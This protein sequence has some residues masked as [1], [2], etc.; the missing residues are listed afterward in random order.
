MKTF[1]ALIDALI[2]ASPERRP[3]IEQLIHDT[4]VR[5]KAV[6]ALD[7][8]GFTLA[9]R[10]DG[11]LYYLCMIRRMQ[12]LTLTIV[13]SHRGELVKHEA[14]NLLAV[15]EAPER[16]AEAAVAMIQAATTE[17]VSGRP[18]L[19]FSIGID[20]GDILVIDRVDCF[21]D[22]VNL[23]HKLGEDIA[24][25]GEVLITHRVREQIRDASRFR[26]REIPLSLSGLELATYQIS[27]VNA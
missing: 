20:Y 2:A 16:A 6:L 12:K 1:S 10:R 27:D 3:A 24:E 9:V 22:A 13:V 23:A 7:M 26:L 15:F 19:K 14:D 8:S 4:F 21:G 17:S 5:R 11:I 18:A 25:A